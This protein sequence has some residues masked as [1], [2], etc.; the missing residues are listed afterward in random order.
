MI[1]KQARC[2]MDADSEFRVDAEGF[3]RFK[4]RMCVLRNSELIQMILNEAHSSHLS[5]YLGSTKMYN[6][7]K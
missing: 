7:M 5:V 6:D 2:E 1:A 4:N 3:L